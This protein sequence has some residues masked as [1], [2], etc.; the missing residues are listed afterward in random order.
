MNT[1]KRSERPAAGSDE[2][3]DWFT[4]SY[5]SIAICVGALLLGGFLV[6]RHFNPATPRPVAPVEAPAPPMARFT[7]V[8]GSVQVR[9]Y[10]SPDWVNADRNLVLKRKDLVKTRPGASAQITFLDGTVVEVRP[11]SL[12]TIEEASEDPDTKQTKTVSRVEA[13][14]VK[15]EVNRRTPGSTTEIVTQT[16]KTIPSDQSSG[17]IRV[18]EG[19]ESD[20]RIYTGGG[21][22]ETSTGQKVE[23]ANNERVQVNAAG[24][25]APK[26]ALPA[27]PVLLAPPHQAEISYAD[28]ATAT[29]LLEWKPSPGA[30]TYHLQVDYS[31]YFNK[32]IVDRADLKGSQV[33]LRMDEGKYYWRVAAID[34]RR[35]L[36][37]NFSQFA[38]FTLT[39]SS[40]GRRGPVGPPPRL[41]LEDFAVHG[42]ILQ[43]KGQTDPG[44]T[45]TV[46]EVRVEV[47]SDGTFN[48]FI[49]LDKPGR[50]VVVVRAVGLSGGVAEEKRPIVV[51]Y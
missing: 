31:S 27:I 39:R 29:T 12:V 15:F 38:R 2:L 26:V 35:G 22:V 5:R 32:P 18:A 19:G 45:V 24:A 3:L 13:G 33:Q 30:T 9:P 49:K 8:D 17:D 41:T 46:N 23:L 43:I 11:D 40:G 20:V 48:D 7:T 4:I 42:S 10:G 37:G 44:S 25:A 47:Q 34:A 14:Q 50:Q 6:W 1:D 28:P 51:T 36:E 21:R 16:A